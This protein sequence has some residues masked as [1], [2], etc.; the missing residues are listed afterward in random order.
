MVVRDTQAFLSGVQTVEQGHH[1]LL[2]EQ[3]N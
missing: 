3:W 1:F 2:I